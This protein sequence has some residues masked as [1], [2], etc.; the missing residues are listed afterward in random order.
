MSTKVILKKF[1]ELFGGNEGLC[2]EIVETI[3]RDMNTAMEHHQTEFERAS[4]LLLQHVSGM[5]SPFKENGK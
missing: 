4:L 5:P 1:S 3:H 2:R